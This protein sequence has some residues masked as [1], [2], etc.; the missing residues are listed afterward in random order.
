MIPLS[1]KFCGIMRPDNPSSCRES[2]PNRSWDV[3]TWPYCCLFLVLH[4]L[5][6]TQDHLV[7]SYSSK[8]F[9]I[10]SVHTLVQQR[11]CQRR[12]PPF[13]SCVR[14]VSSSAKLLRSCNTSAQ[15]VIMFLC[16]LYHCCSGPFPKFNRQHIVV[17]SASSTKRN[18]HQT[19]SITYCHDDLQQ[20]SSRDS[21]ILHLAFLQNGHRCHP[22]LSDD[23]LY[24]I[25]TPVGTT[26][27]PGNSTHTQQ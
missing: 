8:H 15:I 11:R 9:F 24:L 10:T 17:Q 14:I 20:D 7:F 27:H 6:E 18:L 4:T 19:S 2:L 26:I 3:Q 13:H 5:V 16:R 25:R 1:V 23:L 12:R 21:K 22:L